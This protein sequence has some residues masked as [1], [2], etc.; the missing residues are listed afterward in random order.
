MPTRRQ[1]LAMGGG[2]LLLPGLPALADDHGEHNFLFVF[3][4]GGWDVT[5]VFAPLFDSSVVSMEDDATL[6]T[7]GGLS[8]VDSEERPSVRAFFEDHAEKSCVING[9]EVT[10]IT[11]QRCLQILM[12]GTGS[13]GR[14]DWGSRIANGSNR[15]LTLPHVVVG[16]PAYTAD[17][18]NDVVRLGNDG[19]FERL[20]SG[21]SLAKASRPTDIPSAATAAEVDAFLRGDLDRYMASNAGQDGERFGSLYTTALDRQA[22]LDAGGG[23]DFDPERSE[24]PL[25]SQLATALD[26]LEMGLSRCAQV[27]YRG[28]FEQTWDTHSDN[29]RQSDHFEELF[30]VLGDLM[31]ELTLRPSPNGSGALSDNTTVVVWSEMARTPSLNTSNGKDH[32]TF[33]SCLVIGDGVT[34]GRVV[35]GFDETQ[36]GLPLD[37]ASGELSDSG[38]TLD[39]AN[40]GATLLALA[41]VDPGEDEPILGVLA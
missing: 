25:R 24:P 18:A 41:D 33:T 29:R 39:A 6:A 5:R 37:L 16:G 12:T 10:S 19:Q 13:T 11:H 2:A 14:D 28:T 7:L 23:V 40:I 35:G 8:F 3:C 34:G 1:V 31:R 21:S 27:E 9:F 26:A 30:D 36:V 4:F 20:F 22:L 17:L 32:W 15:E 38:V